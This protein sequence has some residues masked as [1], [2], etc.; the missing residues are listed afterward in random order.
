MVWHLLCVFLTFHCV[1][2]AWCFFRLTDLSQALAC[3]QQWV[4]FD[5]DKVLVGTARDAS[6]WLLLV[7]YGIGV[8]LAVRWK[9]WM[10]QREAAKW[11]WL[12]EGVRWGFGLT[13]LLLAAVLS[14]GGE[15]PPFIYF[16][17]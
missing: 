14:P 13:L 8:W 9:D 6:L 15:K 7:A 17:F 10:M 12:N 5:G 1:C 16:Q 11:G 3:V 2:F 4:V